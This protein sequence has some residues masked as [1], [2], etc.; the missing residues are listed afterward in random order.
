MFLL[1]FHGDLNPS[2]ELQTQIL[3]ILILNER[4]DFRGKQNQN[5]VLV[6]LD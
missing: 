2:E 1:S 3:Q 6:W 5:T 4:I